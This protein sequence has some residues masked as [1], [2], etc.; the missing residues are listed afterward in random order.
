MNRRGA[1]PAAVLL[2]CLVAAAPASAAD[3]GE[4]SALS[5]HLRYRTVTW[6]SQGADMSVMAPRGWAFVLTPEGEAR[7]NAG[8]R[9]DVLTMGYRGEG[10]LR[11]QLESKVSA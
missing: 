4:S 5:T 3:Q 11:P 9:P 2:A 6:T 8:A 10:A 1:V 7:F